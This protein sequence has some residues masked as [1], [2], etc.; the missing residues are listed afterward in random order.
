M[1]S[2]SLAER[3]AVLARLGK[4]PGRVLAWRGVG[5]HGDEGYA[6]TRRT[7]GDRRSVTKTRRILARACRPRSLSHFDRGSSLGRAVPGAFAAV[8]PDTGAISRR[9][10]SAVSGV[11]NVIA[12]TARRSAA[13]PAEAA[14][15]RGRDRWGHRGERHG[16][17]RAAR[18][19]GGRSG[20]D[21]A[22]RAAGAR[23]GDVASLSARTAGAR[24]RSSRG[25][26]DECDHR[27]CL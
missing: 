22:R 25:R 15:R 23:R 14:R 19:N 6:A 3:R 8:S 26:C 27:G 7:M 13:D 20:H 21:R 24:C 4:C 18:D 12:R 1:A 16:Q 2:A 17:R 9:P 5:L 11:S 10:E